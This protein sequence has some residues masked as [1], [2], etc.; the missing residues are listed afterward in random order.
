MCTESEV[1][2]VAQ[3]TSAT[4]IW[5]E[6]QSSEIYNRAIKNINDLFVPFENA[7][8]IPYMILIEGA[9]GIGKTKLSK[10][11]ALQ[12]ANNSILKG[13]KLLFLL[14]A[15]DPGIKQITNVQL[16]VKYFCQS[17]K[18]SNT[19]TDWLVKT[20]GKYL[21]IVFDGYD[22]A[23]TDRES[24]S[25]IHSIIAR[26]VL[27]QCGIVIT[28]RPI[29]SSRL[30]DIVNCRAEVLG[31]TERDR[32]DFIHSA[33]QG[34]IDKIKQLDEYLITNQYL[35]FLCYVPL[36]MSILLCL[37]KEGIDMLPK[38]QTFLYKNFIL[39]TITHFLNKDKLLLTTS[40][41]QFT[42]L[43]PP[44][45]QVVK[46]LSQFAFLALQKD[47]LVFTLAEVKAECPNLTPANWYGL[48][49]LK[50]AQYFKTQDG[51]DHESFHF[52]HYSIQ[53]YMAAYYI[54]SISGKNLLS[55]LE[56]TFWNVRY[57]NTWIMYVGITG[58]KHHTFTRFLSGNYLPTWLSAPKVISK[59]FVNNKIKC[60]HL[61]RCS[62]EADCEILSSVENIFEG[63]IIDLS[64]NSLSVNDI[65]TLAVL[66]LRSPDKEWEMLNL[67][68]CNIDGN[69]CSVF[70]EMFHSQRVT[71]KIKKVDISYNNI[72]W[73]SLSRLCKM[74]K[75]WETKELVVSYDALY[76]SITM[77]VINAF[78]NKIN[79][80][81]P[82]YFIIGRLFHGTLLCAYMGEQ[83][84]M[85]LVYLGY[86]FV[87]IDQ[88]DDCKLNDNTIYKFKDL[89]AKQRR[90][91]YFI[92]INN[93][94][95]SYR[96]SYN[97]VSI[98]STMLSHHVQKV[99]YCGSNM[100]SKGA[101]LMNIPSV[102][103]H[104][105]KPH[106]IVVDYLAAVMCHNIQTNSSY[107]KTIPRSL[108]SE[109]NSSLE[110]ISHLKVCRF[111]NNNIGIEAANDIANILF[112]TN[113]LNELYL[114]EN[115]LQS[116]GAIKIAKALQNTVNLTWLN[117]FNNNISEEAADDIA[118]VLSY[119]VKLQTVELGCNH[120]QSAGA[121]KIARALQNTVT[122]T[123]L[124]L[125]NNTVTEEAADDIA[126]ALS[127]NTKL[128]KLYLG[129][130]N[131]Q[132]VGAIKIA[133]ALQN[134]V[135]LTCF[136]LS[137]NNISEEAA[138]DIAA[139]LSHNTK[140]QKLYLGG[141][142][143]QS[144]GA[145]KI[146]K[147]LQN[148]V[149][150]TCFDLSTN[151]ISEEAADDIAAVLSHNTKL[152]K[153]YLGGNNLQ[154]VGAIKIAKALQN[155]VNLTCF[156]LSTNCISEEAADDIATVLSH[157]TKLQELYLGGNNLQSTG[158]IKIV[159]ALQN[160]V[161]LTSLF[162]Q[163]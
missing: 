85:I 86:Q 17:D 157:N 142:N 62:T 103:Q 73:E 32:R 37:A 31:F 42:D 34:E 83:Q 132:S 61:L 45:D 40:V 146:A 68:R 155:T 109:V 125:S 98:K 78:A 6:T 114:G 15:R 145:I 111:I 154:S 129:R 47:Q 70:C 138:D 126:A 117:L 153:L 139:V 24:R 108:A 56:K 19:I 52:L 75:L 104:N 71:L 66:L 26:Q 97:E 30:H 4:D 43:P 67:S 48:G 64:N 74:F 105:D 124:G 133:K 102:I 156:D 110:K 116:V 150:L 46:E 115:N 143:L 5:T 22:E 144:V 2:N 149:N 122:L 89:I 58:G 95:F 158:A 59:R 121:I 39:M 120:L 84:K 1:K 79:K 57:F 77:N 88:M 99:T 65:R 10:E 131:L 81:I 63:H 36:N 54:A 20:D 13:K 11:I 12:W 53:E 118:A 112:Y 160:T 33:L 49:L 107:I 137:K 14:F 161:N 82:V 16:L 92:N 87:I 151:C 76:D 8:T 119:N 162:I 91:N 29:A 27:T 7:T 148:T 94:A 127:H 163:Q 135:N 134:T 28:S 35:N 51:C 140:L 93:V 72:Q 128:Q 3:E 55:L 50:P 106:Q 113:K 136:H 80:S 159:K 41:S 152:Q 21:T 147:A 9:P 23:S 90:E 38:S 18:L 101:Y 44:Y 123:S 60:L 25:I 96:I 69:G 130:N 100:H 141:N